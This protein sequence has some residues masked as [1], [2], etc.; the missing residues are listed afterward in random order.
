MKK[1]I[2]ILRVMMLSFLMAMTG[3]VVV[4]AQVTIGSPKDPHSRALLDL[5]EGLDEATGNPSIDGVHSKKGFLPPRVKLTKLL[6]ESTGTPIGEN[7]RG[8]VVYNTNTVSEGSP[9][10][11]IIWPGLYYN[12][13]E[14]WVRLASSAAETFPKWFY[15]PSFSLAVSSGMTDATVNLYEEFVKQFNPTSGMENEGITI[16]V[17]D[18]A[19]ATV[20]AA[21]PY[22]AFPQAEDFYYYIT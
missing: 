6:E 11:K 22:S 7:V 12:T 8:M 16:A 20:G 13:G 3:M 1:M 18:G 5:N 9:A 10:I 17:S 2:L 4:K 21:L 15:M 14:K 19:P